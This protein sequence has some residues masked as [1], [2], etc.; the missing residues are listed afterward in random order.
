[1]HYSLRTGGLT[2]L[3]MGLK[4]GSQISKGLRFKSSF[5]WGAGPVL[6]TLSVD[7][8]DRVYTRLTRCCAAFA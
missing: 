4:I 2:F 1:M 3:Q 5:F 6:W 8:A 7:L